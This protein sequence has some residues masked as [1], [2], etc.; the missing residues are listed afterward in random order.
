M[1]GVLRESV[2]PPTG[3]FEFPFVTPAP[4]YA[5]IAGQW[6]W[7]APFIAWALAKVGK[8]VDVA[9]GVVRNAVN[10]SITSG[11]DRGMLLHNPRADGSQLELTAGTSQ[12]PL[13]A[14]LAARLQELEPDENFASAVYPR[15][16]DHVR[17]WRS[18]R[19][20][21]DGDGLSEYA[22]PTFKAALHESGLDV[23]P[24]RDLLLLDPPDPSPDG[25]VHDVVADVG[26]NALLYAECRALAELAV[27]VAPD[28]VDTWN[29]D[30]ERLASAMQRMWCP[31]VGAFMPVVRADLDADQPWITHLTPASLIP[32]WAGLASAE[33]TAS[34]LRLAVGEWRQFPL[35]EGRAR[36]VLGEPRPVTHGCRV[37]SDGLTTRAD[38]IQAGYGVRRET[39]GWRA[40]ADVAILTM[41]WPGD[42]GITQEWF[43]RIGVTVEGE[44][45]FTVE[46]TTG[47]G[48]T[49]HAAVTHDAP[50]VVFGDVTG[51]PRQPLHGLSR[52]V[53]R[54]RSLTATL[55]NVELTWARQRP[56]GLLSQFGVRSLHPLDG[57]FPAGAAPTH[58]WSGTV[59]APYAWLVCHALDRGGLHELAVEQARAFN[60]GVRASFRQGFV[61]PEHFCDVTGA[62]MGAPRQA[63]TA[64]VTL[65]LDEELP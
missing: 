34:T 59:W 49:H 10:C 44:G 8:D 40:P 35:V 45:E 19:R 24:I 27:S 42:R 15:L 38:A 58:F 41:S 52:L 62:G 26:L 20:D 25:L 30:A 36:L 5:E 31:D 55:R 3:V 48:A 7:D 53:I 4:F 22:G 28:D 29:A 6:L 11:P 65:L 64:A 9:R 2:Q 54:A 17:W 21:V 18:P 14:W 39:S 16:A 13:I 63:W 47:Q 56:R 12:T 60:D 57:K 32:V 50:S 23:A 37:T 1:L 33:Q 51:P 43:T 46:L 61:A